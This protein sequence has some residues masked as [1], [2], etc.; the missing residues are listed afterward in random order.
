M[1]LKTKMNFAC[2]GAISCI[3]IGLAVYFT[4]PVHKEVSPYELEVI[5][6]EIGKYGYKITQDKQLII[7]QPFIPGISSQLSFQKKEE[8]HRVGMLVRKRLENNENISI[9]AEDLRKL[10]ITCTVP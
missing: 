3:F 1:K 7:Y 8:A 4:F 6:I 9:T 2:L 10:R 5:E